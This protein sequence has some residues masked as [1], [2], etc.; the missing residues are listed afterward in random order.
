MAYFLFATIFTV[1]RFA[2][3]TVATT[4][5]PSL[6]MADS[7]FIGLIRIGANTPH[8]L[9]RFVWNATHVPSNPAHPSQLHLAAPRMLTLDATALAPALEKAR[10]EQGRLFGLLGAIG[11]EQ[12]NAVQRELWSKR[13]CRL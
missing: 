3:S 8:F 11:L 10:L 12:A 1:R 2:A 6:V 9:S 13:R 5:E 7:R 4:G